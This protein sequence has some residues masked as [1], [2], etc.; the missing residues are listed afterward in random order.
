M[1]RNWGNLSLKPDTVLCQRAFDHSSKQNELRPFLLGGQIKGT[2]GRRADAYSEFI[3]Q[4]VKD[5]IAAVCQKHNYTISIRKAGKDTIARLAEGAHPKPHTILDKSM[6]EKTLRTDLYK[7]LQSL[8]KIKKGNL[9]LPDITGLVG[10]MNGGKF[11]G[12]YVADT[13]GCPLNAVQKADETFTIKKMDKTF[14]IKD[15]TYCA[16]AAGEHLHSY[17][18]FAKLMNI[19][20]PNYA[21]NLDNCEAIVTKLAE[22]PNFV[23]LCYTGDYDL[24]EAYKDLHEIPEATPEKK[25]L[26]MTLNNTEDKNSIAL[27]KLTEQQ[28][29]FRLAR[30]DYHINNG[31]NDNT[32][33]KSLKNIV[34]KLTPQHL[35]VKDTMFL[36]QHGDQATYMMSSY[37][38]MVESVPSVASEETDELLWCHKGLWFNT[39]TSLDNLTS[40]VSKATADKNIKEH[41]QFRK[42]IG[43]TKPSTWY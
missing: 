17:I 14:N 11:V 28:K 16:S 7:K 19:T 38:E 29:E 32:Y 12:I 35:V 3:N 15:E 43:V 24:H 40:T 41:D 42:A 27:E 21:M 2:A 34:E 13:T 30:I 26:L 18:D 1:G 9:E 10:K 22:I 5:F 4:E 31:H 36:F 20:T 37:F 39:G 8:S 23:S 6:K 33:L 25:T